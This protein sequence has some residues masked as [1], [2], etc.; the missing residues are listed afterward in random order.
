MVTF[1][2]KITLYVSILNDI[3]YFYTSASDRD[4]NQNTLY[5][6]V[7][8]SKGIEITFDFNHDTHNGHRMLLATAGTVHSQ[9]NANYITGLTD[10]SKLLFDQGAFGRI[11]GLQPTWTVADTLTTLEKSQGLH[12]SPHANYLGNV[13]V[14]CAHSFNPNVRSSIDF[15]IVPKVMSI[16]NDIG[17]NVITGPVNSKYV[18]NTDD[19]SNKITVQVENIDLG[20]GSVPKFVLYETK[21]DDTL[22]KIEWGEGTATPVK[23][24][25]HA[26]TTITFVLDSTVATHPIIFSKSSLPSRAERN[27]LAGGIYTI[28]DFTRDT[29]TGALVPVTD[30]TTNASIS[31]AVDAVG[32]VE[33]IVKFP[34][35]LGNLYIHCNS[36]Q[37]GM[38][39]LYNTG[40]G[41]NSLISIVN[42]NPNVCFHESTLIDTEDGLKEIKDLKRGDNIVTLNG[43]KPLARL[44]KNEYIIFGQEFVRFPQ[45]CLGPN[46]PTKDVLVTKPHPLMFD[47]KLVKAEEFVG[48]IPGVKIVKSLSD[49]YNLLFETQEYVTV[50]GLTFVSHHPNHNIKGLKQEE[51]F[52]ILQYRPGHFKEHVNSFKEIAHCF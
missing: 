4:L 23:L 2:S 34:A 8:L 24:A 28:N 49:Q 17:K 10:Y 30:N 27:P 11:P 35:Y 44:M 12:E 52:N 21:I 18:S 40:D 39:S 19:G 36:H 3:Y 25:I 50:E 46:L 22:V 41:G 9:V 16:H 26:E 7:F 32:P 15:E 29:A 5:E 31:R 13:R 42:R 38:G 1:N 14:F 6:K 45:G 47:F 37:T 43:L 33:V 51:Y 48:K 20:A